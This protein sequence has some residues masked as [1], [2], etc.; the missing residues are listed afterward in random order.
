MEIMKKMLV[1]Q[2]AV[3]PK[4]LGL[5]SLQSAIVT[6]VAATCISGFHYIT[7][8]LR[9][10]KLHPFKADLRFMDFLDSESTEKMS[11]FMKGI[12]TWCSPKRISILAAAIFVDSMLDKKERGHS[13]MIPVITFGS[14]VLDNLFKLK[15]HRDRPSHHQVVVK[16]YSYPSG[17]AMMSS[18]FYGF[19]IYLA[20]KKIPYKGISVFFSFNL[21][22]LILMIGVSRAYLHVH[23]PS[24]VLAGYAAGL[25]WL[26]ASISTVNLIERRT[27][28]RA[29][30]EILLA[31]E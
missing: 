18:S 4:L 11:I 13:F 14:I 16:G 31:T 10:N 3:N 8:K 22:C 25:L 20:W 27:K 6:G 21:V 1:K 2:V 28:K 30:P 24:D 15:Y 23:Y 29:D 19:I 17:H 26:I 7:K 12:S 5:L 9:Q